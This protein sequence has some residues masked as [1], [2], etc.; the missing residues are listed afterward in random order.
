[1]PVPTV[2]ETQERAMSSIIRE[3]PRTALQQYL[4]FT[5]LP[6]TAVERIFRRGEQGAA[7][8]AP[9]LL[10]EGF[11]ATVKDVAGSVWRDDVLR[12]DASLQ[13]TRV[14]ELRR[15][16]QLEAEAKATRAQADDEL[17]ARRAEAEEQREEAGDRAEANR[18]RLE[19]ERADAERRVEEKA[20]EEQRRIDDAA[21]AE[22]DRLE[23][24]ERAAEAARLEAE[25]EALAERRD[26]L[27]TADEADRLDQAAAATRARRRSA[28]A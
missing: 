24:E 12:R 7:P 1:M 25:R 5:R 16:G 19:R 28:S 13:R 3:L 15:A 2:Y 21:A 14:A 17:A 22:R 4:S 9:A 18:A 27:E 23:R 11:E 6:L 20:A 8:W 26:A 10:F